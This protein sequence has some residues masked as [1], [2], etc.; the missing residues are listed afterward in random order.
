[1]TVFDGLAGALNAV[2]G[3]P[4]TITPE[5]GPAVTA[6]GI[7]RELPEFE[8]DSDDRRHFVPQFALQVPKP[9]PAALARGATVTTAGGTRYQVLGVFPDRS[10]AADAFMVAHLEPAP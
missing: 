8:A 6:R 4:V 1:M 2:F 10:P 5:A 9:I 7:L 3:A